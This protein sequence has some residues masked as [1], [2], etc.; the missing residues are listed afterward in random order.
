LVWAGVL[1]VVAIAGAQ[2]FAWFLFLNAHLLLDAANPSIGLAFVFIGGVATRATQITRRRAELER[3]FADALP[4]AALHQI[5]RSPSLLKLEGQ[6]RTVSYLSCA[7]RGYEKLLNSFASDPAGFTHLLRSVMTPLLEAA[8]SSGGTIAYYSA[9]H[10]AAFWNAP[11]DDPD[12]AVHACEAA[13]RMSLA[14]ATVNERLSQ[15]RRSDGSTFDVVEIGVGIATGPAIAGAFAAGRNAYSV[16]GDCTL[17]AERICAVSG[18]YGPATIVSEETRKAA[19]R[20]FAFLEVD[21]IATGSDEPPIKLYAML[22][23][24]LVRASPKFKALSTFHDH[25][26]DSIRKRQWRIAR[27]L[28]D[29]CRRLSGASPKLYDLHLS[30]IT[31]YENHPP[32]ADWDGAFRP[33]LR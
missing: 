17:A 13:N 4:E 24:P 8:T 31:W 1:A 6:S 16:S 22:G 20:S 32:A 21:Y 5:A 14:L 12:H 9:D 23:N 19:E 29:Q 2:A 11:L 7:I 33:I 27:A 3:S 28:I 30:R 10:F 26:F 25:I 15:E 18:Q